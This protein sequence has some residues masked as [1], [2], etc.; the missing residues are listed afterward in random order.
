MISTGW[1]NVT[2]WK[3]HR[4]LPEEQLASKLEAMLPLI[5]DPT[6]SVFNFHCPPYG[7]VLDEAPEVD[8]D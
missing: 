6:R 3:T 8:E 4:E 5:L 1:S 2:P 7:T